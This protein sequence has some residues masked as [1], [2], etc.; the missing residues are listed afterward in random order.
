MKPGYDI[1]NDNARPIEFKDKSIAVFNWKE[2]NSVF[3]QTISSE[4][5]DHMVDDNLVAHFKIKWKK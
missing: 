3:N 2:S 1:I 4:D 5:I